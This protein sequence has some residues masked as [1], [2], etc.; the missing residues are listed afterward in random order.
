MKRVFFTCDRCGKQVDN[1]RVT[2]RFSYP[3]D[4]YKAYHLCQLC[5]SQIVSTIETFV[6]KLITWKIDDKGGE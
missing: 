4:T 5:A 1:K 3:D 2:V 6:G